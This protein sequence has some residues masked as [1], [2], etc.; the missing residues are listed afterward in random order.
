MENGI[1]V[2][3]LFGPTAVGKTEV[4]TRLFGSAAE[5]AGLK[6]AEVINADSMQVYRY[7][8]IGTAK[9]DQEV[10]SQVPHHLIDIV[11]PDYQFTVG[12]FVKSADFAVKEILERGG[13]PVLAGGTA[14][15]LKNFMFGLPETPRGNSEVKRRLQ[16]ELAEWGEEE[17]Y[18]RLMAKDPKTAKRLYPADTYRVLRGLEVLEVTGDPLSACKVPESPRQHYDFLLLGLKRPRELLYERINR[19]VDKMFSQ[20]FREE[21]KDLVQRGYSEADPGMQAIGYKDFLVM[22]RTGCISIPMLKER[23]KRQT[24][25]YAKRQI[26]FFKKLPDV[27][28]YSPEDFSGMMKKIGEFFSKI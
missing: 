15:Y 18:R 10:L 22:R 8:D 9:P 20:G 1:K 17:M 5:I 24:R 27:H 2:L 6:T 16:E 23:I 3:L 19:R 14:F 21:V 11:T 7:M 13:M 25:R 28:W 26:T 4:L 12:D